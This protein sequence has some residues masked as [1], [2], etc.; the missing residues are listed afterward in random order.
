MNGS[1][2]DYLQV[3]TPHLHP[4]LVSPETLSRIQELAEILPLVSDA[5]L[6]SRLGEGQF[7]V[8]FQ[9]TLHRCTLN[10][11]EKF[12]I[13]PVWQ[14]VR[15]YYQEW[16]E[17]DSFLYRSVDHITLEFDLDAPRSQMPIPC[18]GLAL[19]REVGREDASLMKIVER[20]SLIQFQHLASSRW[21]SDLQLCFNSLPDGA[22]IA[23]IGLML[24]RPSKVVKV[25]VK[26]M[27][28]QQ[29]SD[30]L[31][32]IGWAEPRDVLSI[33]VS[34]LSE[35]VDSIAL[36][37]DIGDTISP[38]IGLECF[39]EKQPFDEPR[40]QLFLDHLVE[41]G[42]CTPA[43]QK[44]LL[45][46]PGFSQKADCPDLWPPNLT[47]GDQF[48]SS[49]AFSVFSRTIYEVKIVYQPGRALEAKAYLVFAHSWCEADS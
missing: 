15:D 6:E 35:F 9:I 43:K 34:T 7:R 49:Q 24:S 30:Y 11:P 5:V 2:A 36:S 48:L 25:V 1:M 32:Q 10:L 41:R 37:F 4:E 45:T 38:R 17:P 27:P 26:E 23:G 39:W 18:I 33:L 42:L 29:F 31:E 19:N 20:L 28:P 3:V 47:W 22:R 46:W 8:D 14:A 16:S 40:W 21:E 13:S 44:A 12:L